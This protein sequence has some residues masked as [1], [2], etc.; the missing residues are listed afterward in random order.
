MH[1][2]VEGGH[3][4]FYRF[5]GSGQYDCVKH[6]L[7]NDSK[8]ELSGK[9]GVS[10][11]YTG[12]S[13]FLQWY[14]TETP[15]IARPLEFTWN[16]RRQLYSYDSSSFFPVDGIGCNDNMLPR[17]KANN[18]LFTTEISVV[19]KY[20]GGEVFNFRGDDDVFVFIGGTLALDLGGVHPPL[21]GHIELD[22]L[23]LTVGDNYE[24]KIFHA[25]RQ[26]CGSNF[27]A[28]TTIVLE[29]TETCPNQCGAASGHGICNIGSGKCMCCDG[30]SGPDCKTVGNDAQ[31][32]DSNDDDDD[33]IVFTAP[34]A[35]YVDD[36]YCWNSVISGAPGEANAPQYDESDNSWKD[37]CPK[38]LTTLTST[39]TTTASTTTTTITTTTAT[40]TTRTPI[41][42]TTGTDSSTTTTGTTVSTTTGT[43]TSTTITGTTTTFTGTTVTYTSTTDTSTTGTDGSTAVS[44]STATI[45]T[46]SVTPESDADDDFS[47]GL[48]FDAPG[49]VQVCEDADGKFPVMKWGAPL[50]D[51]VAENSAIGT[52]VT[53]LPMPTLNGVPTAF[54]NVEFS[55]INERRTRQQRAIDTASPLPFGVDATTGAVTVDAALDYETQPS[56]AFVV[57]VAGNRR[58]NSASDGSV[59]DPLPFSARITITIDL[60][61]VVCPA[62]DGFSATGTFPCMTYT[63]CDGG[64]DV[65]I[66]PPTNMTDRVC[67][68]SKSNIPGVAEAA[69]AAA[70]QAAADKGSNVTATTQSGGLVAGIIAGLVLAVLL[71]ALVT[72]QRQTQQEKDAIDDTD[73]PRF[74]GKR[75]FAEYRIDVCGTGASGSGAADAIYETAINYSG[76]QEYMDAAGIAAMQA[77]GEA[78][79]AMASSGSSGGPIYALGTNNTDNGEDAITTNDTAA[80]GSEEAIYSIAGGNFEPTYD[81]GIADVASSATAESLYAMASGEGEGAAVGCNPLYAMRN[82]ETPIIPPTSEDPVYAIGAEDGTAEA[83][84]A[85][86]AAADGASAVDAILYDVA[87]TNDTIESVQQDIRR[88]SSIWSTGSWQQSRRSSMQSFGQEDSAA[89]I[90]DSNVRLST[91]VSMLADEL[92]SVVYDVGDIDE[93]MMNSLTLKRVMDGSNNTRGGRMSAAAVAAHATPKRSSSLIESYNAAPTQESQ[94]T[95]DAVRPE[96]SNSTCNDGMANTSG[97]NAPVPHVYD[98]SMAAMDIAIN[99]PDAV[100][101]S[102][103][104]HPETGPSFRIKSVRRVNPFMSRSASNSSM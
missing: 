98:L 12:S 15:A 86:G 40:A 41:T 85:L 39:T 19:F 76:D 60:A 96:W 56:Y 88:R 100:W 14:S 9:C 3:P 45:T 55:L 61:P 25:E 53:S 30:W 54:G 83:L 17:G 87:Q 44:T 31:G 68:V 21:A 46:T 62:G 102:I 49:A 71:V 27:K 67:T 4:D 1:C 78:T 22:N 70:A 81:M 52:F 57:E 23:G 103:E 93:D 10:K 79:Y 84:Y 90:A 35:R 29:D 5:G 59:L 72:K 50:L 80:P 33:K 2:K 8:P 63:V 95:D 38:P 64:A 92:A 51:P 48:C 74:A 101:E 75:Q 43:D 36:S 11:G 47:G 37:K 18:F 97:S 99:A 26:C 89:E 94:S 77:G 69:S 73:E 7:N 6:E 20:K 13:N 91:G 32:E 16:E 24:M 42:T 82:I 58:S 34:L 104:V 28:E 66:F 65:E